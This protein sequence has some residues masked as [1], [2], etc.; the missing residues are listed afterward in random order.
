MQQLK[1]TPC[2][3]SSFVPIKCRGKKKEIQLVSFLLSLS[4]YEMQYYILGTLA[5]RSTKDDSSSNPST[6]NSIFCFNLARTQEKH[7]ETQH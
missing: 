7:I 5:T 2:I 6:Q 4:Q 3:F 1:F